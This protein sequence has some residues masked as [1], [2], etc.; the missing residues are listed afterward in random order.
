MS[1]SN[2]VDFKP[3]DIAACKNHDAGNGRECSYG[4]DSEYY[5]QNTVDQNV[6][7]G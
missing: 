1:M 3:K 2:I 5:S 7:V 4:V 6:S